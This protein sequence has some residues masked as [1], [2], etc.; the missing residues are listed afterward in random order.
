MLRLYTC[1]RNLTLMLP[2]I[3][4]LL[5][6][7]NGCLLACFASVIALSAAVII[8][9]AFPVQK[10]VEIS[11]AQRHFFGF[12]GCVGVCLCVVFVFLT[13]GTLVGRL[14]EG[15]VERYYESYKEMKSDRVARAL[16]V[17]VFIP[18]TAQKIKLIGSRGGLF[19]GLGSFAE[20]S[21][22]TT[23]S[24]FLDF[25]AEKKYA[26]VTN[27]VTRYNSP[28]KS[29]QIEKWLKVPFPRNFMV[30]DRCVTYDFHWKN[31]GSIRLLYDAQSSK[32]YGRYSSN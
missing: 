29:A 14:T 27:S 7:G 19:L 18:S 21:C 20:F 16:H 22:H 2:L 9:I 23:E 13:V 5:I 3:W 31:G 8:G 6:V 28:E 4:L 30:P 1:F 12:F 32:L 25:A 17:D 11:M 10:G 26:L 24:G 15:R